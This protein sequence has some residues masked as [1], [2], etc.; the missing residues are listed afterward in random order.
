MPLWVNQWPLAHEYIAIVTET[1]STLYYHSSVVQCCLNC[2]L[3][4]LHVH[5][6]RPTLLHSHTVV[7]EA[8]LPLDYEALLPLDY[9]CL[10]FATYLH[11]VYMIRV[12][13]VLQWFIPLPIAY[14]HVPE[15]VEEKLPLPHAVAEKHNCLKLWLWLTGYKWAHD[16]LIIVSWWICTCAY[17]YPVI[18]NV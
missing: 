10:N 9:E 6:P 3:H 8:L 18:A 15:W 14:F 7:Q 17:S 2:F 12:Q 4:G 13:W 16:Q 1:D 5:Q 11:Y